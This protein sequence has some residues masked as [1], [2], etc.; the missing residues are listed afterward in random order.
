MGEE[1]EVT[2]STNL[3][4]PDGPLSPYK[5]QEGKERGHTCVSPAGRGG[6][7]E[8]EGEA[9]HLSPQKAHGTFVGARAGVGGGDGDR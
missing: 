6:G 4:L 7:V 8:G 9:G 3:D 1:E 5:R 2:G